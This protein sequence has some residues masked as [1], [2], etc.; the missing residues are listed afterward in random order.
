MVCTAGALQCSVNLYHKETFLLRH[1]QFKLFIQI[2]VSWGVKSLS[3]NPERPNRIHLHRRASKQTDGLGAELR[4]SMFE[5]VL[6][7]RVLLCVPLL[8]RPCIWVSE[9]CWL[10]GIS[11]DRECVFLLGDPPS[12]AYEVI[13]VKKIQTREPETL[14]RGFLLPAQP[15]GRGRLCRH[16]LGCSSR[17]AHKR[18]VGE[19]IFSL[20]CKGAVH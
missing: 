11:F 4:D 15:L 19:G 5:T 7:E 8:A 1:Q 18:R 6:K 20:V 14:G 10:R 2:Q 17:V 3:V 9:I 12:A 16:H 13:L